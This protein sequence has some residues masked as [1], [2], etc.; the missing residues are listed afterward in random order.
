MGTVYEAED[1]LI[2]RKMAIKEIRVD[3]TVDASERTELEARFRLEYRSAGT[4]S[5]SNIVTI[6]DVLEEGGSYFIAMEYVEGMS[7]AGRLK[8]QSRPPFDEILD[9]ARQIADG[10]DY[11]HGRGIVHRDIKPANVLLTRDGRPKITDFGLAKWRTSELT[12]TGTVLGTPAYM[13]PEQVTGQDIDGRSDQFSFAIILYLMLTGDQ[14]FHAEHPS[15]ILYK[16]VHEEPPLPRKVNQE[17]PAAVDQTLLRA[18]AKKPENRYPSCSALATALTVA[19]SGESAMPLPHRTAATQIT[20]EP[21]QGLSTSATDAPTRRR[22]PTADGSEADGAPATADDLT[23]TPTPPPSRR[24]RRRHGGLKLI[25]AALFIGAIGALAYWASQRQQVVSEP[26]VDLAITDTSAPDNGANT[27]EHTLSIE[28]GPTGAS[29]RV[30]GRDTGLTAPNEL[31]LSGQLGEIMHI[32]LLQGGQ[33]VSE[34]RLEL[35]PAPPEPWREAPAV[36]VKLTITS[37]PG[38][39]AI[40]LGGRDTGLV[41]PAEIELDP[42][43]TEDATR[44]ILELTLAGYDRVRWSFRLVEL[45]DEQRAGLHFPLVSSAPPGLL[46]VNAP[47]PVSIEI[48][49]RRH[50]PFTRGEVPVVAGRHKVV[51]V[52]EDVFLRQTSDVEIGSGERKSLRT[53]KAVA[54]NITANPANCEVSVDGVFVD[55][56]PINDRRMVIGSHNFSF[57]WPILDVRK[58]VRRT[59]SRE[60]QRISA[61]PN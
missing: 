36:P 44:H 61:T 25:A 2:D 59:V 32:E 29:I 26:I 23:L 52:A 13:S 10:L 50:G 3:Q 28:A 22:T 56:T 8:E 53:P 41:T 24:R 14:P 38:G 47:Y 48:G 31:S 54:V 40:G 43:Q 7:L 27:I 18:L 16:I 6:Y 33:V 39:A 34:H 37:A 45:S 51:L 42:G 46:T 60:G 15:T 19:L 5:H 58:S 35:R 55:S 49:G 4:L 30:N 21:T 9:L 11:A 1:P 17:L 12:M 20:P 57:Y